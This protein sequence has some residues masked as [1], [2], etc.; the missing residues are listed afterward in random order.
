MMSQLNKKIGVEA[1]V[2][3]S[4]HALHPSEQIRRKYDSNNLKNLRIG[5]LLVLH[6]ENKYINW[7]D[8]PAIVMRQDD[9]P[10]IELHAAA[11]R[12]KLA[13]AGPSEA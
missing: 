8:V 10:N 9:F 4:S 12:I 3:C 5:N 2:S 7:R 6:K 1:I 13:T 11:S